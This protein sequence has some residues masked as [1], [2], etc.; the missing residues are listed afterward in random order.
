MAGLESVTVARLA[1]ETWIEASLLTDPVFARWWYLRDLRPDGRAKTVR[2]AASTLEEWVAEVAFGRGV[3]LVPAGL[4]EEYRRPGVAFTPVS[5]APGSVLAL[6]W[7]R[8][9]PPG[10]A[11][12]LARFASA[13]K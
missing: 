3:N 6:A 1:E 13:R 11:E 9:A 10:P 8:D 4:T 7:R 5:D 12:T 2:S